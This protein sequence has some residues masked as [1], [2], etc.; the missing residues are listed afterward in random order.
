MDE[1]EWQHRYR[2][3]GEPAQRCTEATLMESSVFYT[4]PAAGSVSASQRVKSSNNKQIKIKNSY[5]SLL[6]TPLRIE[7]LVSVKSFNTLEKFIQVC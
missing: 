4:L 2:L 1:R 7:R 6:P 5:P 3:H